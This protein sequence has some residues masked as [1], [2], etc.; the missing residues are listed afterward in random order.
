MS[1]LKSSSIHGR[2]VCNWIVSL[3]TCIGVSR[4][5]RLAVAVRVCAVSLRTNGRTSTQTWRE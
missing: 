1:R 5:C 3:P 4:R 2:C